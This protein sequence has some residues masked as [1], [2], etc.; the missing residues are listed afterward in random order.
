MG[1]FGWMYYVYDPTRPV[2]CSVMIGC[3]QRLPAWLACV[4]PLP[5][6]A[7]GGIKPSQTNHNRYTAWLSET[8][9]PIMTALLHAQNLATLS[10]ALLG[11]QVRIKGRRTTWEGHR[12][13]AWSEKEK[14][15]K[16]PS[17]YYA[18]R[19]GAKMTHASPSQ[20]GATRKPKAS[21]SLGG[22][23]SPTPSG[24]IATR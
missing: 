14:N 20:P 16:R 15:S 24:R 21:H 23:R 18:Q 6:D 4:R 2:I 13:R 1:A 5:F 8:G 9:K 10:L 7:V 3:N 11:S 12:V 17:S 22:Q 19:H